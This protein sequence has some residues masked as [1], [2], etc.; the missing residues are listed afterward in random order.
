M[1]SNLQK[2]YQKR[3]GDELS[4]KNLIWKT[5]C[6]HYFQQFI[7]P[8]DTVLDMGAGYCEFINNIQCAHK[9]AVDLNSDVEAFAGN[10]VKVCNG[11]LPELAERSKG[12][13]DIVFM[14][15]FLEHLKSKEEVLEILAASYA[16]L[17]PGG[18]VII[19]QP[20]IR[21]AFREYWDFFDHNIPFSEKSIEEALTVSG[22]DIER[23]VPRFLPYSTKSRLP[24]HPL[25]IWLY[26][27]LPFL[28][29]IFG[30]QMLVIA[31][32]KGA[33]SLKT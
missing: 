28:W 33:G 17:K 22:F 13:V 4:S 14:S 16:I 9:Y 8:G 20:N 21:Y 27:K 1:D 10:D 18:K 15:N 26:L 7:S 23:I 11:R 31:K 6:T 19:L 24:Q 32:C 3:F 29:R 5:L 30:K 25:L 12:S 2:L